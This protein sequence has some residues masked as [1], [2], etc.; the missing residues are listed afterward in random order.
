MHELGQ[1]ARVGQ[2]RI[3]KLIN[4]QSLLRI[5][6]TVI[7][8]YISLTIIWKTEHAFCMFPGNSG[9]NKKLSTTAYRERLY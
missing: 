5:F 7:F 9:Y 6:L 1:L 2:E 4:T 3:I 8:P